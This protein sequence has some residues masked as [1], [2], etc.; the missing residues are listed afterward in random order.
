MQLIYDNNIVDVAFKLLID[1]ASDDN[2]MRV[3]LNIYMIFILYKTILYYIP[4]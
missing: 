1:N 4:F 3:N 2:I